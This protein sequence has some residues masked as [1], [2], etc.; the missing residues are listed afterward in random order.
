M[1]HPRARRNSRAASEP[2]PV[3]KELDSEPAI[4]DPEI[5]IITARHCPGHHR[6]HFLRD[7]ADITLGAAEVA[8]AVI[9]E[10]VVQ[11]PEQ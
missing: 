1:S 6:L 9:A 10:A 3:G 2:I 7:D 8:E 11:V 4:I 5:T